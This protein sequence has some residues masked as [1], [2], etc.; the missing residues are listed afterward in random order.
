[1]S[2]YETKR[3]SQ[4]FF[5]KNCSKIEKKFIFFQ[6]YILWKKLKKKS[7]SS[8]KFGYFFFQ[9]IKL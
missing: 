4:N 1:M 8:L 5:Q 6:K 3:L 7:F 9:K 2:I